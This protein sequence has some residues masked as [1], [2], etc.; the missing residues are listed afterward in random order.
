MKI[1]HFFILKKEKNNLKEKSP[2]NQKN[3]KINSLR[4]S[5]Q[6]SKRTN[7]ISPY[8]NIKSESKNQKILNGFNINYE[9]EEQSFN[10]DTKFNSGRWNKDEHNK[11]LKG[12][13]Q[14]GNDWKMVQKIIKTRSSSQSRS[15]AQKFF[16]KL[17]NLIKAAKISNEENEL[18]E[19]IF[20]KN[21]NAL[22]LNDI[23]L[24]EQEKKQLLEIIIS[25]INL[26]DKN[27]ILRKNV[28]LSEEYL[29]N[30]DN[31]K[32]KLIS[33]SENNS[34]HSDKDEDEDEESYNLIEDKNNNNEIN[35]KQG[36]NILFIGNK[37]K[38]SYDDLKYKDNALNKLKK[39]FNVIKCT[40]FKYSEEFFMNQKNH[41]NEI[42]DRNNLNNNSKEK[43]ES[44]KFNIC[45]N[46]NNEQNKININNN[47]N[48]NM[49]NIGNDN[50][51]NNNNINYPMINGN[52][53]INNN[54]INI[55]NNCNN[56]NNQNN[57]DLSS[58][59]IFNNNMQ[60]LNTIN[61]NNI[62]FI[63]NE[64]H[65]GFHFMDNTLDNNLYESQKKLTYDYIGFNDQ[66]YNLM[67]FDLKQNENNDELS[68]PDQKKI[69]MYYISNI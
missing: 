25:S 21:K 22:D 44:K 31:Y 43:I 17:K 38:R 55:M 34:F 58:L 13:I 15:H 28:I 2:I 47:S 66:N 49:N 37:R 14:Y 27:K 67:S 46:N 63:H 6:K 45:N 65:K 50:V 24:T 1:N 60:N 12:L 64:S 20:R 26:F 68:I 48:S 39:I 8:D 62:N 54:I 61:I 32:A 23:K 3:P 7:K 51:I 69:N 30:Y 56:T 11:F 18:Y 36:K 59:N 57:I 19:Y 10:P 9:K 5:S 41:K 33:K 16:L 53:I 4:S 40:K 42:K 35:K 29:N 52:C